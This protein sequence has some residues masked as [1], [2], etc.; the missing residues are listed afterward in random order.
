[1]VFY[2]IYINDACSNK[3][4]TYIVFISILGEGIGF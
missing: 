1:L 2:I 3:H 4:K